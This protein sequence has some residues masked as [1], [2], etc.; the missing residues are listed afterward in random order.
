MYCFFMLLWAAAQQ[1]AVTG[2]WQQNGW[3]SYDL[4][5]KAGISNEKN[6][7]KQTFPDGVALESGERDTPHA[8]GVQHTDRQFNVIPILSAGRLSGGRAPRMPTG[9]PVRLNW[10]VQY[11]HH[12]LCTASCCCFGSFCSWE[13]L[14]LLRCF[15]DLWQDRSSFVSKA[16]HICAAGDEVSDLYCLL[17]LLMMMMTWHCSLCGQLRCCPSGGGS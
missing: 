5:R 13:L 2:F 14:L 15:T 4:V 3:V 17:L 10:S 12:M 9:H 16:A 6:Y 7:V 1:G 11:R 8:A